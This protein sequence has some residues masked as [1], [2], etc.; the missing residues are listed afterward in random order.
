[1]RYEPTYRP[2]GRYACPPESEAFTDAIHLDDLSASRRCGFKPLLGAL[3]RIAGGLFSAAHYSRGIRILET[4]WAFVFRKQLRFKQSQKG[5][6]VG[7]QRRRSTGVR[8][9]Y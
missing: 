9:G 7:T 4:S 1:M 5:A 3:F 6:R 2:S 8:V